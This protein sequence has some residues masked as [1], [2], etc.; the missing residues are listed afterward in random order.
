MQ[1]GDTQTVSVGNQLSRMQTLPDGTL[2]IVGT[3]ASGDTS[4]IVDPESE[5]VT[6]IDLSGG[7]QAIPWADVAI[8]ANGLGVLLEQVGWHVRSSRG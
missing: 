3:D 7:G 6:A 4:W 1:T 5:T 8:D 2:L